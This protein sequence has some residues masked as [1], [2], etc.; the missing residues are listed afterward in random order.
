MINK[1]LCAFFLG[2]NISLAPAYAAYS[3][4]STESSSF[5]SNIFEEALAAT[6]FIARERNA[7]ETSYFPECFRPC[8]EFLWPPLISHG[9]GFIMDT[10]GYVVTNAHVV[11]QFTNIF[12]VLPSR[13]YK[14]YKA[15]I[16]GIDERSDVAILKIENPENDRLPYLTLGNSNDLKIGEEVFAIGSPCFSI[17]ASS[18]TRGIISGKDRNNFGLDIE[19]FLQTDAAINH[20]NSGGPLINS[21][22]RVIGIATLGF[23]H[24]FAEG[25]S[26]A[27]PSNTIQS[28]A[29]QLIKHGEVQYGFLGVELEE[30]VESVFGKYFFDQS[31]GAYIKDVIENSPA[32]KSGFKKGDIIVQINETPINSPEHL[33]NQLWI[34]GSGI[35]ITFLVSRDGELIELYAELQDLTSSTISF[36]DLQSKWL[37]NL[38]L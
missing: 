15:A 12:V 29:Q 6:V 19:G 31:K 34:L 16:V 32:E 7:F 36:E 2:L 17:L 5:E 27:V 10:L 30:F 3:D 14:F 9:S 25:L 26:F 4:F 22:G 33:K 21:E 38:S 20:G 37:E 24:Y 28:I 18:V 8:Y 1:I 11:N 23:P 13:G 35:P